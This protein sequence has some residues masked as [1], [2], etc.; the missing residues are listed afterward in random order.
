MFPDAAALEAAI[1]AGSHSA[2]NTVVVTGAPGSGK[3]SAVRAALKSLGRPCAVINPKDLDGDLLPRPGHVFEDARRGVYVCDF[4]LGGAQAGDIEYL[5]KNV[6]KSRRLLPYPLVLL[7]NLPLTDK[8][9]RIAATAKTVEHDGHTDHRVDALYANLTKQGSRPCSAPT[10][11]E[12]ATLVFQEKRP[13]VPDADIV[14]LVV[15]ENV[16]QGLTGAAATGYCAALRSLALYDLYAA[17]LFHRQQPQHQGLAASVGCY[18]PARCSASRSGIRF[19]R[20]LARKSSERNV[21]SLAADIAHISGSNVS[22]AL[23][24]T[25]DEVDKSLRDRAKKETLRR[26]AAFQSVNIDDVGVRHPTRQ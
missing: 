17:S 1:G 6:I 4:T 10:S 5:W 25:D 3:T 2:P 24:A 11:V 18:L 16:H 8:Q 19:T 7:F 20:S 21:G 14:S 22:D 15:H 12:T 9:E 13:Y 23:S 26:T